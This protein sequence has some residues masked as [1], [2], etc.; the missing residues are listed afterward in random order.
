[1]TQLN[2][3]LRRIMWHVNGRTLALQ[4]EVEVLR[5]TYDC[6]VIFKVGLW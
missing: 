5:L 6:M 1:M 3:K 2:T 4:D